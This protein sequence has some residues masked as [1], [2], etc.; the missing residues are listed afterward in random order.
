MNSQYFSSS[1]RNSQLKAN[2]V[3]FLAPTIFLPCNFEGNPRNNTILSISI[4]EFVSKGNQSTNVKQ[5]NKTT[6]LQI[7]SQ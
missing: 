2:L 5:K 7:P 3:S 4:S 6:E 1:F